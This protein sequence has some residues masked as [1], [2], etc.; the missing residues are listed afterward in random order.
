MARA[1]GL[2][3]SG[4]DKAS[5]KPGARPADDSKVLSRSVWGFIPGVMGSHGWVFLSSRIT[6]LIWILTLLDG[7]GMMV[8]YVRTQGGQLRDFLSL[9]KDRV[10]SRQQ[11][12]WR[13]AS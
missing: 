2:A 6:G 3:E 8:R 5:G 7:D 4:K 10:L 11:W 9:V 1:C 12:K 13:E